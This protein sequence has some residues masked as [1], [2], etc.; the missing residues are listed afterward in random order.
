[1][2]N[3]FSNTALANTMSNIAQE[4]M[5]KDTQKKT[6]SHAIEIEKRELEKVIHKA[7]E[8]FAIILR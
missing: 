3:W 4:T 5:R 1:M 7:Q 6:L 2:K 8:R